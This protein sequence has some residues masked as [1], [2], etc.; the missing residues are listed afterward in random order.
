MHIAMIEANLLVQ[1]T[2][3]LI[4]FLENKVL[5]LLVSMTTQRFFWLQTS[6]T[7]STVSIAIYATRWKKRRG[8]TAEKTESIVLVTIINGRTECQ[9]ELTTVIKNWMHAALSLHQSLNHLLGCIPSSIYEER[10]I[11]NIYSK[12]YKNYYNCKY[13]NFARLYSYMERRR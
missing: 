4:L 6:P 9:G 10:S 1:Y 13:A 12:Y 11:P 7:P 5:N 3:H 8:P 2:S